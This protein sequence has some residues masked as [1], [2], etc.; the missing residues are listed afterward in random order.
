MCQPLANPSPLSVHR[1]FGVEFHA[2]ADLQA[3]HVM[4]RIEHIVSGQ[5]TL[6]QSQKTLLA[7]MVQI[8]RE[9]RGDSSEM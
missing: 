2:D 7:F 9:V 6:F 4:G 8:L 5:A 3:G 1:A